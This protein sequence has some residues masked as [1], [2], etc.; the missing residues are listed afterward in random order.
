MGKVLFIRGGA[1]GDFILTLPAIRLV[2]ENLPDNR[3]EV[4]GYPSIAS[5]ATATGLADDVR[6]IEDARLASFFAPGAEL[7]PDWCAYFSRFDL[8]V[9]YLYDPDGFFS[10]NLERTDTGTVIE[11]PF[12]PA[13]SAPPQ[14]AALQ[15]AR[16]LERIAL[17]LD[18]PG[19]ELDY[20]QG[21]AAPLDRPADG[22]RIVLHPGSGSPAKN[23]SFESWIEILV[24]L[25][26][27]L[28]A[29]EFVITC[30]E[31]ESE[32]IEHFVTLA[33]RAG[34]RV[35]LLTGNSLPELG[36]LFSQSDLFLGHDSGISHLA[37]SSGIASILL[38]GP[39]DPG[40]WAPVSDRLAIVRSSNGTMG[41]IPVSRV[42]QSVEVWISSHP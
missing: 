34:L 36:A 28:D 16:P 37:A 38:F 32:R 26:D 39:T 14:P 8:V 29:V 42:R 24:H 40:I 11:A 41:G 19:L 15:L 12:R 20:A 30:G 35:T 13:E 5:L 33:D 21:A 7:D 9:S 2:R 23:W 10:A 18:E 6:S 31:A 1:V 3:V 27:R 22:L 25:R 17:F 4:L